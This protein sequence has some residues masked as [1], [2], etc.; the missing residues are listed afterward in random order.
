MPDN[1][2][3]EPS[4]TTSPTQPSTTNSSLESQF[5]PVNFNF[6]GNTSEFFGIWIVN[7]LLTIVTLGIYSAWAKVR[8]NQ[9]FYGNT[10]L[11]THRFAYLAKP[12]D[13]LKG[14]IIAVV[15]FG[16]YSFLSAAF[17]TI[18]LGFALIL[19]II[20]PWLICSSMRFNL[21]MTSY[22][23][24]RFNFTGKYLEALMYLLLLPIVGLLTFGLAFPFVL[25]KIDKFLLSNVQ[26][27][28]KQLDAEIGAQQY[29]ITFLVLMCVSGA[30]GMAVAMIGALI[31]GMFGLSMENL[32]AEEGTI[33][34]S[35]SVMLIV[36]MGL[37]LLFITA[38]SAY[39]Q[40]TIRNY[41]LNNTTLEDV[42][43]FSSN[44]KTVSFMM[45]LFTN[46]LA[47]VFSFGLAYPWVKV[48]TTQY[49]V[50]HTGVYLTNNKDNISDL[51]G[52]QSTAL[53]DEVA[54][55]FDVDVALI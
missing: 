6:H 31:G 5:S 9:Y 52:D 34:A 47:V 22:R 42:A 41:I 7:V 43:K 23:N 45:L 12:L 49:A 28:D 2:T 50:T 20:S 13:I 10:E 24:V 39:Y 37:Y 16:G 53:G 25:C 11:D 21:R 38:M 32:I 35:L 51:L 33:N 19:M 15:L 14:R 54:N 55:V 44:Y 48:R 46:L 4:I 18:A 3:I 17:P 30:I 36:G 26:Y 27:G 40:A 29:Y 8:T 1:E